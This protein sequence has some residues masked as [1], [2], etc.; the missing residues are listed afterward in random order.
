MAAWI[1][2]V[3]NSR[4]SKDDSLSQR[5]SS[6]CK[7]KSA[8]RASR[9]EARRH[10]ALAIHASLNLD[11]TLAAI[12][13]Q[14]RALTAS[15]RCA[16]Y[17]L[18]GE[19]ETLQLVAGHRLP[20]GLLGS[21]LSA[22]RGIVGQAFRG[23]GV[24][25]TDAAN[26]LESDLCLG[27]KLA[28]APLVAHRKRLG[29]LQVARGAKEPR[30]SSS[31]IAELK[32][33]APLAA[34]AIANAQ[35]F[36]HSVRTIS[37]LRISNETLCAMDDLAR[38]VVDA[39]GHPDPLLAQAFDR[40]CN[41]LHLRGGAV[42][43]YD[44]RTGKLEV[45]AQRGLPETVCDHPFND[46]PLVEALSDVPGVGTLVTLPLVAGEN[47][48]GVLQALIPPGQGLGPGDRD[49][50]AIVANQLALGIENARLFRQVAI[51]EQ[52][53]QL[54]T[55][56]ILTASH[57]LRT[58]IN[59]AS[60]ALEL[61]DQYLEAP[62]TLQRE[63]LT[64]AKLGI[65]RAGALIGDLLDLE[66]IERRVG[67]TPGQCDCALLLNS[68]GL[69]FRLWAQNHDKTLQM[70]VPDTPLMVWGDERLL[71]RV[72]S[73]LVDNALKYTPPGG[74]VTVDACA[75]AGQ[76]ILKVS[77][78]GLGIPLEAQPYVFERFYRLSDQP[79]S[80]E[81]T[82]LGLTIVKSIVEQHGGRV[83]VTS[84]PGQ[85]SIFTVSLPALD[86]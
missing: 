60:G 86:K 63:A 2:G 24:L 54:Q 30:F 67:M 12:V 71:Q 3:R 47:V 35:D 32:W 37:Q 75:K 74:C 76:V 23:R 39:G 26:A 51:N 52:M 43:L 8:P 42:R 58:P 65:E 55:D 16:V 5:V 64:L 78:T 33:F 73:N 27:H 34:Q 20:D 49:V 28:A 62:S 44:E 56:M 66:R 79:G 81:G 17:L 50:L 36:C 9:P 83:G 6:S 85:G 45:V 40:A 18:D 1:A 19:A 13:R 46:V 59:L 84:Q 4:R 70:R 72:V 57:E 14:A 41:S 80:V 15:R 69:E 22:S 68:I 21:T 82:G 48:V 38:A 77:D 7:L 53:E 29:V 25:V 61:L 11:D 10:A 31:D